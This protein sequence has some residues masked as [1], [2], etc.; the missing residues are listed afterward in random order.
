MTQELIANM[1]G[2]HRQGVKEAALELQAAG[3]IRYARGHIMVID[4]PGL[5]LR[6]CE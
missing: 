1:R 5:E 4:R 3:R 2:V 6:N